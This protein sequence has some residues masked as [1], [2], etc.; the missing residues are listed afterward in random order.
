MR[1]MQSDSNTVLFPRERAR[2]FGVIGSLGAL[3]GAVGDQYLTYNAAM[4]GVPPSDWTNVADTMAG[5]Q[6]SA[7]ALGHY[8]GILGIPLA[9]AG[10]VAIDA[11]CR[12]VPPGRRLVFLAVTAYMIVVGTVYHAQ[13]AYV[14]SAIVAFGGVD[15]AP[16]AMMSEMSTLLGPQL[17][18]IPATGAIAAVAFIALVL[19]PACRFPRWFAALNPGVLTLGILGIGWVI[20]DPV[21]YR[22]LLMGPNL[23]LI[24][25]FGTAVF[26]LGRID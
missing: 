17:L 11:G 2:T 26:L 15:A 5:V 19:H 18:I 23:M 21:G 9:L 12:D 4:G 13:L 1:R 25:L 8:L 10:L 6:P 20:P 3:L 22:I 7:A 24:T 16:A 14:G